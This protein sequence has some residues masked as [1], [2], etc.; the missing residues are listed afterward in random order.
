[1]N[2]SLFF[3]LC[4]TCLFLPFQLRI[5]RQTGLTI[6]NF[7]QQSSPSGKIPLYCVPT[8]PFLSQIFTSNKSFRILE[9]NR[10]KRD[11]KGTK[12]S[13]KERILCNGA[14]IVIA[15]S[16]ATSARNP[17]IAP[18]LLKAMLGRV[19]AS[20]PREECKETLDGSVDIPLSKERAASSTRPSQP[21]LPANWRIRVRWDR[22]CLGPSRGLHC[23]ISRRCKTCDGIKSGYHGIVGD[24][25]S[26]QSISCQ[27]HPELYL[28]SCGG[29][30][31]TKRLA[32]QHVVN[33]GVT[34][35]IDALVFTVKMT[36]LVKTEV[37]KRSFE[38]LRQMNT[39]IMQTKQFWVTEQ[40]RG[41]IHA[42]EYELVVTS[43]HTSQRKYLLLKRQIRRRASPIQLWMSRTAAI[44]RTIPEQKETATMKTTVM[45][46]P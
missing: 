7:A 34:D 15:S 12:V 4:G 5:I 28:S 21:R 24:T 37:E 26:H 10:R 1:M 31:S 41:Q 3:V 45:T 40:K 16:T 30:S 39:E 38:G 46:D 43:K 2:R 19:A 20:I 33:D 9:S 25:N 17:P 22:E 36:L 44:V 14:R 23:A 32:V 6:C 27:G 13:S 11:E 18:Q 29:K 8:H 35:T 42:K